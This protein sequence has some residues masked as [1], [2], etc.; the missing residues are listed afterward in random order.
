MEDK[1]SNICQQIEYLS[2]THAT[3]L[4][5]GYGLEVAH[6]TLAKLRCIGGGPP[7]YKYGRKVLYRSNEILAWANQRVSPSFNSTSN[8]P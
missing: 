5:A 6:R 4:L 2:P 8:I 7:F 3:E 1:N